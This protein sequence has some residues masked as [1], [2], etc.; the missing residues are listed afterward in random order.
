MNA[1]LNKMNVRFTREWQARY[2]SDSGD[3]FI[4]S[5]SLLTTSIAREFL[6]SGGEEDAN[7]DEEQLRRLLG[8]IFFLNSFAGDY[9]SA[10]TALTKRRKTG[11][12]GERRQSM[13]S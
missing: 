1:L 3:Y 2:F 8:D 12:G 13:P 10:I 7:R 4:F 9:S 11:N 6:T 5:L